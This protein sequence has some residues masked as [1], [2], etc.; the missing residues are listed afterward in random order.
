M[1]WAAAILS[2]LFYGIISFIPV[3]GG[4]A[5][6]SWAAVRPM[7]FASALISGSLFAWAASR[8][9]FEARRSGELELLVTTPVGAKTMVWE[10]WL[11]LRRLLRWPLVV[12][13]LPLVPQILMA[14]FR[15]NPFGGNSWFVVYG[16]SSVFFVAN[17]VLSLVALCWTGMWYGLKARTQAMAVFQTVAWVKVLPYLLSA[18]WMPL[19]HW[20]LGPAWNSGSTFVSY[21]FYS[22]LPQIVV[23]VFYVWLIRRM[24]R[25][26]LG[27]IRHA[28]ALPFGWFVGRSGRPHSIGELF[29]RVRHWTPS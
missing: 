9:F 11:F 28:E 20:L 15:G 4:F 12:M 29:R 17:I 27:E 18:V 26:L 23:L 2:F 8:F 13:L 10:Q 6:P 24:R 1:I 3:F 19:V 7:S 21:A 16:I 5:G 14:I 25:R 22:W